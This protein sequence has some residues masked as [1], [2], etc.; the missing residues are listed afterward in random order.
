VGVRDIDVYS[1][2]FADSLLGPMKHGGAVVVYHDPDSTTFQVHVRG[3]SRMF[4]TANR[5]GNQPARWPAPDLSFAIEGKL[6]ERLLAGRPRRPV[7]DLFVND[8]ARLSLGTGVVG[9]YHGPR[10]S[11]LAPLL[12]NISPSDALLLAKAAKVVIVVDSTPQPVQRSDLRAFEAFY[13]FATCDTIR[14]RE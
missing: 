13:R 5:L 2:A 11:T 12:V 8:T 14:Y 3:A 4:A 10:S 9:N 7:V 6:G 1:C